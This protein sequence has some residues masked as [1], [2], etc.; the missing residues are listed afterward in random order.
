MEN[1]NNLSYLGKRLVQITKQAQEGGDSDKLK[2]LHA[3]H[4][5]SPLTT[6]RETDIKEFNDT[7]PDRIVGDV[8]KNPYDYCRDALKLA[9]RNVLYEVAS[10]GQ[11]EIQ[12]KLKDNHDFAFD[13]FGSCIPNMVLPEHIHAYLLDD[14]L[15]WFHF[16]EILA[17]PNK[18]TKSVF[19]SW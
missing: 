6:Q 7:H 19:V 16:Q 13:G 12:L 18:A 11:R 2:R 14:L 1:I 17:I 10:R 5:D 3:V 15:D 8:R 4:S 9:S